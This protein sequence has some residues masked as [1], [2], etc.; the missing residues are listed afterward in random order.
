M[1]ESTDIQAFLS[2]YPP[3]VQELVHGLRQLVTRTVPGV[4]ETIDPSAKVIGYGFGAGYRNL[5]CT[6][7]PSQK[8]A[9]LGIVRG[10][11]LSDPRQLLHGSGKVHRHIA[12]RNVGDLET[13]GV[14]PLLKAAVSAWKRRSADGNSRRR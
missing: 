5:V 3:P 12:F 14:K 13:P 11:E 6:I 2:A 10:A 9:K 7:I 1:R 4:A 8:G